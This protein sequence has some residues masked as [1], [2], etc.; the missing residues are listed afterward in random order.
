MFNAKNH[1]LFLTE[2]KNS[3]LENSYQTCVMDNI[4]EVQNWNYPQNSF[5]TVSEMKDVPDSFSWLQRTV[6]FQGNKMC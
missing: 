5:L 2:K 4:S 6:I 1:L 3:H